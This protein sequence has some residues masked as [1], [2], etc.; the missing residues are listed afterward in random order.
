[1]ARPRTL[2]AIP[3]RKSQSNRVRIE[4]SETTYRIMVDGQELGRQQISQGLGGFEAVE[5]IDLTGN[6]AGQFAPRRTATVD[7]AAGR[8]RCASYPCE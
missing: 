7:R 6:R 8:N 1:M 3:P 2:S 4:R 5:L